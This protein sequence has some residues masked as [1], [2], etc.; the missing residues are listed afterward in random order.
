MMKT[1]FRFSAGEILKP[2]L[3]GF[4][5]EL[6]IGQK[7]ATHGDEVRFSLLQDLFRHLRLHD[8]S[9]RTH[10]DADHPFDPLGERDKAA[11]GNGHGLDFHFHGIMGAPGNMDGF[12]SPFFQATGDFLPVFHGDSAGDE[13]A[14]ADSYHQWEILPH[15]FLAAKDDLLKKP[16][17]AAEGSS[18]P[19]PADVR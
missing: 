9:H 10:R 19:V 8:F 16:Q 13:L 2:S 6:G 3:P 1:F 17:A 18:I 12:D 15:R 7:G 11:A 4:L 5:G 14:C